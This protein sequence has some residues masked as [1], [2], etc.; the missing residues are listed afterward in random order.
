MSLL[1]ELGFEGEVKGEPEIVDEL[2][3]VV[4]DATQVVDACRNSLDFLAAFCAPDV[5]KYAFPPIYLKLWEWLLTYVHKPRDFSKLA[6]GLP[7]GFAK[8]FVVKLFVIF[9]ILFT[10]KKFI[11]V[12]CENKSKAVNILADVMDILNSPNV[13]RV[14]GDW[15]LGKEKD[16]QDTKKF[17]FR[18]RDI[19]LMGAGVDTGIRGITLKNERPDIIIFDDI[20]SRK[21]AESKV[22]SEHIS[23]EMIG[24]AMKA[25]SPHGCMYLFVGNMYPTQYS[26]LR[27]L[28]QSKEWIKFITGGILEDGTSL[29]EELQ[30]LE[31]LL[32]EFR[33][34]L[35]MGHPEIFYAEVLNDEN[36]SANNLIDLGNL[37]ELPFSPGDIPGGNFVLIDPATDGPNADAVSVGYFEVYDSKPVLMEV[38]E[39]NFSPGDTIR[40][41]LQFCLTKNCKLVAIEANAYQATLAYWFNFIC[42]QKQLTGI[43]ALPVYSG[44]QS[45]NGRIIEM[46]RA[47]AAG[48]IFIDYPA[49]P[50]AHMQMTQFKPLKTDNVDGILDLLV[51]APKVMELYPEFVEITSVLVTQEADSIEVLSYEDVCGF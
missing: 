39:G 51:Y 6:L 11:L 40:I 35:D 22:Q 46:L 5:Y 38:E 21:D 32:A 18:G 30:P 27:K 50:A 47:Y 43:Q 3:E 48:D 24:T 37:P 2:Q 14:F 17:G 29:W 10:K 19:I 1:T 16:T 31:Q 23:R 7:R 34:D 44:R 13:K 28:K 25:K 15:A 45:K 4:F 42:L 36:A 33:S 26:I 20:Q 41:A 49:R 12:I 9:C 8:T